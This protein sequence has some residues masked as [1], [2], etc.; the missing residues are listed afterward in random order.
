MEEV[1]LNLDEVVSELKERNDTLFV[2][3]EIAY[4]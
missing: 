4:I 2:R 3:N 1:K